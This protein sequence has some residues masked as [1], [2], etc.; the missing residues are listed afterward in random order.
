MNR[1]RRRRAAR[2]QG[3]KT[4]DFLG[5]V[6]EAPPKRPSVQTETE[7]SEDESGE[8][9]DTVCD[10]GSLRQERRAR[11]AGKHTA[12]EDSQAK[13]DS[14]AEGRQQQ[15]WKGLSRPIPRS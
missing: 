6:Q 1:L 2:K 12:S 10:E 7:S 14:S 8:S 15:H 9:W 11:K 4:Q 5:F 13:E 3:D